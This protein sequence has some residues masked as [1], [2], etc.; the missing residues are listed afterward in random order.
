MCSGVVGGGGVQGVSDWV[1]GLVLCLG[2]CLCLSESV[3][4]EPTLPVQFGIYGLVYLTREDGK[5]QE[6]PACLGRAVE[7]RTAD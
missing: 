6:L 1:I 3:S 7:S 5:F 4:C 2:L